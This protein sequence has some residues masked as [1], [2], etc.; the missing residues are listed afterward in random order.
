MVTAGIVFSDRWMTVL[1][2]VVQLKLPPKEDDDEYENLP[3]V[4]K[5]RNTTLP[6][7]VLPQP[8]LSRC[9][10]ESVEKQYFEDENIY[11]EVLF[12]GAEN[13]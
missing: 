6:I 12:R 7:S 11:E 3:P 9:V 13:S 10:S 2:Y 5:S 1:Q 8:G 4:T